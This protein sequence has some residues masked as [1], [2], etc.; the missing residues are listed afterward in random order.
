MYVNGTEVATTNLNDGIVTSI[1]TTSTPLRLG[2]SSPGT[3]F[4]GL[5][6][7]VDLFDRELAAAEISAIYGADASGKC[8]QQVCFPAPSGLVAWWPGAG[9]AIDVVGSNN[10]VIN[11]TNL[12]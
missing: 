10:G 4:S 6:D 1:Q 12:G 2:G 3:V 5:I 9:N 7:E 8:L 11:P